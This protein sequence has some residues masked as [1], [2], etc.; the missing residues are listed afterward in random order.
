MISALLSGLPVGSP[1]LLVGISGVSVGLSALQLSSPVFPVGISVVYDGHSAVPA[2]SLA[3]PRN[4]KVFP[5]GHSFFRSSARNLALK[6]ICK[7]SVGGASTLR[8]LS[9]EA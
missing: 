6:L 4:F 3:L 7:Y 9:L 2:G 5:V 8:H 1:G